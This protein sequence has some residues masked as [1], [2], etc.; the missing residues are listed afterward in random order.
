MLLWIVSLWSLCWPPGERSNE[1]QQGKPRRLTRRTAVGSFDFVGIC[2][3]SQSFNIPDLNSS[4]ASSGTTVDEAYRMRIDLQ[5]IFSSGFSF[6]G[7]EFSF[8]ES[9][10]RFAATFLYWSTTTK[11]LRCLSL[12]VKSSYHYL[13]IH[14]EQLHQSAN[15]WRLFDP[16]S[17][18]YHTDS[19]NLAETKETTRCDRWIRMRTKFY[20][21]QGLFPLRIL[22]VS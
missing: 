21:V 17:T 6:E 8:W 14:N 7:V 16:W 19:S 4:P 15:H 9:A 1:E 10:A 12:I 18:R 5:S 22:C 20:F 11:A 3:S 2:S 13:H